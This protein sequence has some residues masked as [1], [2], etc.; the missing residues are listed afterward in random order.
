MMWEIFFV[1]SLAAVLHA[2]F[3]YPLSL[4][5]IAVV[6]GQW[7]VQK[8]PNLPTVTLIITVFNEEERIKDKLE[9]TLRLQYPREKLQVLVA[10]DGS[11][12]YT[13]KIVQGYGEKG[14][15]LLAFFDRRGKEH[16][17][18]DAV[19]NARGDILVFTDVSTLLDSGSLKEIVSNFADYSVGCVSSVDR[20]LTKNGKATGEN[21]YVRYEMW[22]RRMESK[23]NSLVGLSGSFFAAKREVCQ[24]FSADM[25]SDF[26]TLLNSAK[27]GLRGVIDPN[28]VG[29]Y[30][31]SLD[32]SREFDRKVRTVLR[33]LTVFFH[34]LEFLNPIRFGLFSY[35]F[36]CH[37][38]LRWLVPFFLCI[39]LV[40]N[41]FL[42]LEANTWLFLFILQIGFYALAYLGWKKWVS[43]T[44]LLV[45]IPKFFLMVNTS[46]L[47]AWIKYLR[48]QRVVMWN[49]TERQF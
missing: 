40:A 15:E 49:P 26:R 29:T 36:F 37:K 2:Y 9:N 7:E 4:A 39:A 17:Q 27:M 13:N 41:A 21:F 19:R 1:L 31:D 12:D 6:R 23:T 32:E 20:L 16:A 11:T 8:G 46:I 18:T 33:G 22:L 45:K 35:Q 25:Q 42:A 10:S 38:L 47:L 24:N 48:G 44:L 43:S 30:F 34:H 5:L 14:I 3:G 28:A